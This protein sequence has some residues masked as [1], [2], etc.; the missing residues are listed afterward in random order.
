MF[1]LDSMFLMK[2]YYARTEFP[3]SWF[4][5]Q[6][7]VVGIFTVKTNLIR[8]FLQKKTI[9]LM[10]LGNV[11]VQ[12]MMPTLKCLCKEGD[13]IVWELENG[14]PV[15]KDILES[16]CSLVLEKVQV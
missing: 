6:I 15:L 13:I 11:D 3:W 12:L 2:Q 16:V 7:T 8:P 4:L 9:V 1:A 10:R 5:C 14:E